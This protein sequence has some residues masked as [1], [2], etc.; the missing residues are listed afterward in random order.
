MIKDNNEAVMTVLE[1]LV[2]SD[3]G[4]KSVTVPDISDD[5]RE[6]FS[7]SKVIILIIWAC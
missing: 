3:L 6:Y 7:V 4:E 2:T 5:G 1:D